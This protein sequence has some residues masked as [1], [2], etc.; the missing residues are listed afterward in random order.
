MY[1][2]SGQYGICC[3]DTPSPILIDISGKGFE[4]TDVNGGVDFDFWGNGRKIRVSWTASRAPNGWLVLDR[5]NNGV[6]DSARE[7]FGTATAQALSRDPNGFAALAEFDVNRDTK[8]DAGDPVF[9]S[10]R[11]WIDTNHNGISEALELFTLPSMGIESISLDYRLT[12]F[13]DRFGNRFAYRAVVDDSK[14]RHVG[15][16]AFDVVLLTR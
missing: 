4:L 9:A 5:N 10:L 2:V 13:I 8:I 3:A 7:M 15:R 11:L 14:H 6:V 12:P 16:F 1:P